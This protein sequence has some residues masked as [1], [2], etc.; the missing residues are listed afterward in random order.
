VV[1]DYERRGKRGRPPLPPGFE[2][3]PLDDRAD[4]LAFRLGRDGV[5][6]AFR[7][8]I[9]VEQR[10]SD[11]ISKTELARVLALLYHGTD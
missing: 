7:R 3:W 5:I 2:N 11:R 8:E 4:F 10:D 9:G 1:I 6:R